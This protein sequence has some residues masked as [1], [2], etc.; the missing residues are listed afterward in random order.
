MQKAQPTIG[1]ATA[2]VLDLLKR[3]GPVSADSLAA[4]LNLTSMAVRLHLS[5]LFMLDLARY[6]EEARP[7]GRPVQMWSATSKAD[8]YFADSHA[9]L[10]A[11]L[12]AQTRRAFGEDGMERI[13]ELRTAEQEKIYRAKV[14]P[15][16][17]LRYR[18]DALAKLRE[19][20]GYMVEIHADPDSKGW[21]FTENHCPVCVAA[22]ACNGICREELVL[23]RSVL[24]DDVTIERVSHI[25]AG[26][27]RCA[28]RV[29]L[30]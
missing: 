27:T 9:A 7:R 15:R 22:R 26:A 18:L 28:Y 13:L 29:M 30:I 21:L 8:A 20:E 5:S 16:L 2:V 12:I 14:N 4:A 10:T 11:D 23:F 25:L 3:E 24:G 19:A 6:K 17:A 1:R